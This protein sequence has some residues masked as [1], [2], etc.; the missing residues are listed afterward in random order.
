MSFKRPRRS[1]PSL[2]TSLTNP[3]GC[4]AEFKLDDHG[5]CSP[6]SAQVPFSPISDRCLMSPLAG[7]RCVSPVTCPSCGAPS[8]GKSRQHEGLKHQ[9]SGF[10][11][12]VGRIGTGMSTCSLLGRRPHSAS[13]GLGS[14]FNQHESLRRHHSSGC[15]YSA[16]SSAGNL[17]TI[18]SG[19]KVIK[20]QHSCPSNLGRLGRPFHICHNHFLQRSL[21]FSASSSGRQHSSDSNQHSV[22]SLH[23][24]STSLQHSSASSSDDTDTEVN[25]EN[26]S[27]PGIYVRGAGLVHQGSI[28][29]SHPRRKHLPT[30]GSSSDCKSR[31][32]TPSHNSDS[33]PSSQCRARFKVVRHTSWARSLPESLS[34]NLLSPSSP[35]ISSRLESPS[36][37]ISRSFGSGSSSVASSPRGAQPALQRNESMIYEEV[38]PVIVRRRGCTLR[39]RITSFADVDVEGDGSLDPAT[40]VHVSI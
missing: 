16:S 39:V 36:S 10:G 2:P 24:S 6:L 40:P 17:N 35:P 11:G 38:V 1:L 14:V 22:S 37:A 9:P 31:P 21:R 32:G 4:P 33:S 20:H 25:T 8:F 5:R 29:R 26:S 27:S 34:P 19:E 18:V 15:A 28:P 7:R 3:A 12:Y 30:D 23:L 13:C